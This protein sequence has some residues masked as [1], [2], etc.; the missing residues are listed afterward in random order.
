MET[1]GKQGRFWN[2]LPRLPQ[3]SA[4]AVVG[5]GTVMVCQ[6]TSQIPSVPRNTRLPRY[7][8]YLQ[9]R[10]RSNRVAAPRWAV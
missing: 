7:Q 8:E 10:C 1:W 6:G 3:L 9:A 2:G 5:W 4:R